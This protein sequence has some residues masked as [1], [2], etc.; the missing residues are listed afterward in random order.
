MSIF[1]RDIFSGVEIDGKYTYYYSPVGDL[2]RIPRGFTSQYYGRCANTPQQQ[3][4]F[5]SYIVVFV[6]LTGGLE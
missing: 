1:Y 3:V 6:V 5:V 4:A 2:T